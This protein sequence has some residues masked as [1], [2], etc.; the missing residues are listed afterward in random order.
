MTRDEWNRWF[1]D[2]KRRLPEMAA[3][4]AGL[5]E[6][7]RDCW[8]EDIFEQHEL[9]D[10]LSLNYRLMTSGEHVAKFD[11]DK[12]PSVFIRLLGEIKGKREHRTRPVAEFEYRGA[13]SRVKHDS[14]MGAVYRRVRSRMAEYREQHGAK[15][16]PPELIHEWV[17]EEWIA[18]EGREA[19][20]NQFNEALL[21]T[22]L[23]G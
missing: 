6:E 8:F 21:S 9:E 15:F 22:P 19:V 10:A 5:P 16:T 23:T 3:Y 12:L 2:L 18:M 1:D 14:Q 13:M 4:I 7:T 20:N 11:R 17:D